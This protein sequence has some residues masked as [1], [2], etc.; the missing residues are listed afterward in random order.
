MPYLNYI[1]SIVENAV[2][3]DSYTLDKKKNPNS[4][5]MHSLYTLAD[6]GNGIELLKLYVDEMRDPG[7][8]GTIKRSYKLL[9]II[10]IPAA[11]ARVQNTLSPVTNTTGNVYTISDLFAFVKQNDSDFNP[12]PVSAILNND[13]TPKVV[14][15]GSRKF[16]FTVFEP[17]RADD[18]LS[19][20]FA[21]SEEVASTYSGKEGT[22]KVSDTTDE[23]ID[24]MSGT[25]L[26]GCILVFAA[27][28]LSQLPA[29]AK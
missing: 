3:L 2:L 23:D 4:V 20:F 5:M 13:G 15:H 11:S 17:N 18:G 1:D 12:K 8:D 7:T 16:G 14:Y 21:D 29:K 6:V 26:A 19:L 28:I 25:E 9:D 22:R 24:G 27:V 10:N